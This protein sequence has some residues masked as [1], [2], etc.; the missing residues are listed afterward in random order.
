[1]TREQAGIL[2]IDLHSPDQLSAIML[3][4]YQ[5]ISVL[6]DAKAQ[7]KT[8][9]KVTSEIPILSGLLLEVLHNAAVA[10]NNLTAAEQL[11]EQ[12]EIVRS[13]APV[14]RAT[15]A[16]IP[17]RDIKQQITMWFREQVHPHV[18]LTFTTRSDIGG[19]ILLQ[20][21]SH[22]YDFSFRK[23][24]LDKKQRISEIFAGVKQ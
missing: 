7:A 17:N 11:L 8:A 13:K 3:E 2:P 9:G 23:Q 22:I 14:V 12:L 21:G 24:I 19:G 10:T 18:L 15:L 4:L 5:H 6:R 1:M 20:A 16:A